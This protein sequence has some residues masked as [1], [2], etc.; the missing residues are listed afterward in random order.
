M[1]KLF[2]N[3]NFEFNKNEK[4]LLTT[5]CRQALKQVENDNRYFQEERALRSVIE[6]L[7]AD[8]DEIKL[9]R[10]EKTRLKFQ[11]EQ[12]VKFMKQNMNKSW[13]L[14]RWLYKSMLTQYEGI[15]DSHFKQ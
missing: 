13:F 2:S 6:K 9:T 11:L 7:N 15:L 4:K 3:Y 10:D 1:K 5:F 14:K 12:N 8:T